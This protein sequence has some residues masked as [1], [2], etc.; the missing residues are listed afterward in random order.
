MADAVGSTDSSPVSLLANASLIWNAVSFSGLPNLTPFA[1][2]RFLPS[3]VRALIRCR[4]NV[5]KPARI[6]II[7]SPCGVVVSAQASASERNLDPAFDTASKTLRR[8]LVDLASRSR[9]VT[10]RM[11]PEPMVANA[12]ARAFLSVIA[13]ETFSLNIR[14]A[15]A[16]LSVRVIGHLSR[17][18]HIQRSFWT[19]LMCGTYEQRKAWFLRPAAS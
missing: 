13:P 12:F 3:S 9:R 1:C 17:H 16:A 19:S 10:R 4:S 2:A 7:N 11:S 5:A 6:V 18:G 8:S 14:S 15:P